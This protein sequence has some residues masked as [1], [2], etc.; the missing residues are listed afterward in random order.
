MNIQ[1]NN[2]A[3]KV[4]IITGASSGIGEAVARHL[5]TL[6]AVVSLAA[7]RPAKLAQVVGDITAAG[8]AG[9]GLCY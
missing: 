2:I 8:G 4:V 7:R 3:G 5:A 9:P 6:G 1:P